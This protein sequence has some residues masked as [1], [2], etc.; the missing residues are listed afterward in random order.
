MKCKKHVGFGVEQL[1]VRLGGDP[2]AL[3]TPPTNNR[4]VP[5]LV[6]LLT[7][8]S[9]MAGDPAARCRYSGPLRSGSF[10]G[11]LGTGAFKS[12]VPRNLQA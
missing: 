11:F 4:G 3:D 5:L 10:R 6:A 8:V 9:K 2:R 7:P 12:W 1:G